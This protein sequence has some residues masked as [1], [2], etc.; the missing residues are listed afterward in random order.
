MTEYTETNTKALL[1]GVSD[2]DKFEPLMKSVNDANY[3]ACTLNENLF[4]PQ[5]SISK[6]TGYVSRDNF[7]E[8]LGSFCDTKA[9]IGILYFSGHGHEKKDG[10]DYCIALSD[11][12]ESTRWLINEATKHFEA[13]VIILDCCYAGAAQ[14]IAHENDTVFPSC[15]DGCVLFASSG[16]KEAS[17]AV[18]DFK[19]SVFTHYLCLSLR[20]EYSKLDGCISLDKVEDPLRMM[21]KRWNDTNKAGYKQ[22]IVIKHKQHGSL[23][24]PNPLFVP[25]K[26]LDAIPLETDR[27][28]IVSIEP[29]HDANKR[30]CIRVLVDGDTTI[31]GLAEISDQ[32]IK[33]AGKQ[34]VFNRKEDEIRLRDTPVA[35][36]SAFFYPSMFDL[37]ESNPK[38][39]MEWFANPKDAERLCKDR[40]IVKNGCLFKAFENFFEAE[41][42]LLI[43]HKITGDVLRVIGNLFQ[44]L[45]SLSIRIFGYFDDYINRLCSEDELKDK[46]YGMAHDVECF[47]KKID[48]LGCN[49]DY[50][51]AIIHLCNMALCLSSAVSYY[52]NS[53]FLDRDAP[54]R[55][56]CMS[57]TRKRFNKEYRLFLNE[58]RPSTEP[59]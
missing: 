31:S 5:S 7:L 16:P 24:F 44:E 45:D 25:Y 17:Y 15:G 48:R 35:Q 1:V 33:Y 6:L 23:F 2:Y 55:R 58:M 30:Y 20:G 34:Q 12:A 42:K 56:L 41:H 4:I 28:S 40:D 52:T 3:M 57:E 51:N 32:I 54:N 43:A 38:Y 47:Q 59:I 36:L 18:E 46:I 14:L 49:Q 19:T 9:D 21:M 27:F 8:A 13:F 37:R 11:A 26:P 39:S 50:E 53:V 10:G 22:N 29:H